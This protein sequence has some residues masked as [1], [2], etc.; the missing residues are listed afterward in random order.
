M[1]IFS[2]LLIFLC[3]VVFQTSLPSSYTLNHWNENFSFDFPFVFAFNVLLM[4]FVCSL[5]L[6]RQFVRLRI[7]YSFHFV[8]LFFCYCVTAY[9]FFFHFMCTSNSRSLFSACY[10]FFFNKKVNPVFF[11]SFHLVRWF[12]YKMCA[13][14]WLHY[15]YPLNFLYFWK[16][17]TEARSDLFFSTI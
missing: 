1:F 9:N 13:S 10:R 6:S 4:N 17:S 8:K 11:S 5:S 14:T 2:S 12:E 3:S 7:F 15:V 16:F